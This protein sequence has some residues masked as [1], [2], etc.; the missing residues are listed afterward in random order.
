[1]PVPDARPRLAGA[2][3]PACPLAELA[4]ARGHWRSGGR[5]AERVRARANWCR[6]AR[7][8]SA[9]HGSEQ[10]LSSQGPPQYHRRAL[11][12]AH[13]RRRCS[14]ALSTSA[15]GNAA[16]RPRAARVGGAGHAA[17]QAGAVGRQPVLIYGFDD[18]TELQFDAIETLGRR[19]RPSCSSRLL[20]SQVERCSPVAPRPSSGWSLWP[21]THA[22][23]PRADYYAPGSRAALHHLERSLLETGAARVAPGGRGGSAAGPAAGGV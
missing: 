20:T 6:A 15:G 23:P 21:R 22:R 14:R 16:Q 8:A 11:R 18:L 17:S 5:S 10:A 4:G 12:R 1:M 9:A 13:D 3:A 19:G 7:W 2:R